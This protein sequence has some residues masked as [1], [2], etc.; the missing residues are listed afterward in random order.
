MIRREFIT[1]L[2]GA[3]VWPLTARAAGDFQTESKRHRNRTLILGLLILRSRLGFLLK[4]GGLFL[5]SA[6]MRGTTP[7][8]QRDA[9]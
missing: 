3:A 5:D 4:L 2:G 8:E 7:N 6:A 9:R 1:L